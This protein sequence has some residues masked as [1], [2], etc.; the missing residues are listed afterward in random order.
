MKKNSIF[1]RADVWLPP[2]LLI[3]GL[4][5]RTVY[6]YEYA[7]LINFDV[8]VGPDV[9]EYDQR[10]REIL[11]GRLFP[12]VPDIHAPLY[13]LFLAL[14]YLLSGLSIPPVRAGQLL[15]NFLCWPALERLLFRQGVPFA[16][17]MVFLALGML[18][19]IPVFHQAELIS[20]SLLLPLLTVAL[21]MLELAA[22]EFDPLKR[23]IRAGAAGIAAGLAADTHPLPLTF[24]AAVFL[25][26]LCRKARKE[27]LV[28]LA[29]VFLIV[30][31]VAGIKTLHYGKLTGIQ[32]NG[33][34][35]FWLGNSP[36]AT[37]GCRLRPGPLWRKLHKDAE[38]EALRRG[39][40]ADRIWIGRTLR[41]W[42]SDPVK[43]IYL[44]LK[45][46]VMV[47]YPAELP[48]GADPGALLYRT[49]IM[50]GGAFTAPLILFF[51]LWG[52]LYT[53][54]KKE[55][56]PVPL[57]LLAA[58]LYAG[59]I[60]TVTSGRYRL[61]MLPAILFFSAC[62]L[63]SFDWKK[64]FYLP[65]LVLFL[66][67]PLITG[68][69]SRGGYEA[70]ALTGE[71]AWRKGDAKRALRDLSFARKGYYD[72]A[73]ISNQIGMLLERHGDFA[74]AE[75]AYREAAAGDPD[76][77]ESWMNLANLSARFPRRHAEAQKFYAEALRRA[78]NSAV[79]HYNH[80]VFLNGRGKLREAEKELLTALACDN[81]CHRA[82]NLLGVIALRSGRPEVAEKCF[83]AALALAPEETGYK[84]NL[85]ITRNGIRGRASK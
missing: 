10:A 72:P 35:N 20:E 36:D 47:W 13:P 34:F 29:G 62:G 40:S 8:P 24:A 22:T 7:S 33:G 77:M 79:L 65:L 80:A 11:S 27:A 58:A 53:A 64:Y 55:P 66:A 6:L 42:R 68:S 30:L 52:I 63:V 1:R 50:R 59:Q 5:L 9:N 82:Y 49:K 25:Y 45:K 23:N 57:Q 81:T 2:L 38:T 84:K 12:A 41:F 78:P 56:V 44:F 19:V 70:A 14:C 60:L 21:W 46:A 69:F 85:E 16:V 51:A 32:Q 75:R 3:A 26:G 73:R 67:L 39:V 54:K 18:Y 4:L 61:A 37:G 74:G 48:A 15:L 83:A 31:P 76:A 17:R 28:F 71:A 43:G